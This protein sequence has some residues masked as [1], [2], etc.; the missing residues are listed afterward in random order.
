MNLWRM[1]RARRRLGAVACGGLGVFAIAFGSMPAS[2][3]TLRS[4]HHPVSP[5]TVWLCR[6]GLLNDP[7]ATSLNATTVSSNGTSSAVPPQTKAK[8]KVDCFFVY[9][10]VSAEL[11]V[12]SD[13]RIQ[14]A[15]VGVAEDE[16]ERFSQ[17]CKV[18]AP[19]Y[20]QVTE[21]ALSKG[22]GNSPK[23]GST[24]YRSLLVGWNDYL[25]HDNH[26]RP[27][28]FIGHS[29]GA[30]ILIQLLRSQIDTNPKL[31]ARMVSAIILGGNVQVPIGGTVGGSFKNIP[32]CQSA[33]QT[34]CVIA[35]STFG[36]QPPTTALFSRPGQGVSLQSGQTVSAGQQV[37]CVNP[38]DFSSS[39]G[40]LTPYFLS[41]T[42]QVVGVKVATPW[43]TYP[44]L[45]SAT[46]KSSGGATWLQI[47]A[48][49]V[50]G[51][52][53]PKVTAVLGPNWGYHL[54]DVS[55]ALGNLV[56][57]VAI[58]ESAFH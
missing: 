19:M 4:A 48:A 33:K 15:E 52:P 42:S 56:F 6:P 8:Q 57:D 25:A 17:V 22:L 12:N 43:V 21:L 44:G 24:A 41:V 34:G 54:D 20:R 51:D 26:G 40:A 27:I 29:Q 37:A 23:A 2:A 31:R 9:P 28:V 49:A 18:W 7:C 35:Y 53:R 45:Y 50:S 46:C 14:P 11:R 47:N 3:S 39:T 32:T 16:A 36:V 1:D 38:T 13:L 10:T 5:K 58:E 55:L 30:A